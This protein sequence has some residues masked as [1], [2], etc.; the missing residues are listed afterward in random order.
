[1]MDLLKS[2]AK[3]IGDQTRRS[4]VTAPKLELA[5]LKTKRLGMALGNKN[6]RWHHVMDSDI[7]T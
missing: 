7:S 6:F 4:E 1:M 2:P 5:T 3:E